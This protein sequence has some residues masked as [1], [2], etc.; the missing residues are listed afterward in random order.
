MWMKVC[1][2]WLAGSLRSQL[3]WVYTLFSKPGRK[4]WKRLHKVRLL[5]RIQYTCT[6]IISCQCSEQQWLRSSQQLWSCGNSQFTLITLFPG[7]A[8][9]IERL[10]NTSCTYF[11]LW[12]WS[13]YWVEACIC[14][15][16]KTVF[17]LQE[18]QKSAPDVSSMM[19]VLSV[20]CC[21]DVRLYT[22][23]I[24]IGARSMSAHEHSHCSTCFRGHFKDSISYAISTC[25]SCLNIYL[26]SLKYTYSKCLNIS[27]T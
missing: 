25:K 19:R 22:L 17:L 18:K 3:I 23:Q 9:V 27:N 11:R 13:E 7:Q 8:W 15:A 24:K 10:T 1:G 26:V 20:T 16:A 21:T 4:F 6:F 12:H 2:S 5:G 14:T